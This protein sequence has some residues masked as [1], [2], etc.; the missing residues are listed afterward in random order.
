MSRVVGTIVRV[1]LGVITLAALAQ[2]SFAEY[3]EKPVRFIV[4]YAP[5][6]GTDTFARRLAA[7]LGPRLGQEVVVENIGGA[8]GNLGMKAAAEA[9][10]DGYTLVFAL[11]AQFAINPSLFASIPYDPVKDF[12]PI[13][14]LGSVPYVLVVHPS[15]E[16]ASLEDLIALA[17]KKPGQLSYASAGVGSGAHLATELL[18]TMVGVDMLHVSYK[19]AG[20]A[21]PDLLS[22][23][24]PVMFSTFAPIEGYVKDKRVRP[25]AV[26]SPKRVA[27][28]PD[29]PA[30]AE[31]LPGYE[32]LTW[33]AVAAPA[34]T[35]DAVIAR[36]NKAV[37]AALNGPKLRR[38]L[39]DDAIHVIGSSPEELGQY[40]PKEIKKWADVIKASGAKVQ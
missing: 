3:P 11:N 22:G 40:L 8:G 25:I 27:A 23:R 18:K 29:L 38:Q 37:V 1:T 19:G 34:G 16:V 31:T 14:L 28:L 33:Y 21:Y 6:G 17:R 35:P 5:G 13:S 4:P 20:A 2:P 32:A 36:V 15:L 24:V 10:P 30:V 26:S 12:K 7:E 39:E 9:R